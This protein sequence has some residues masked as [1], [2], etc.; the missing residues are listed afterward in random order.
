MNII[1]LTAL[2]GISLLAMSNSC[3]KTTASDG[4]CPTSPINSTSIAGLN[5]STD[6]F[7]AVGESK[8][9]VITSVAQ[10]AALFSCGNLPTIDFGTS[11]LLT[12]KIQSPSGGS[13]LSQ[14]V[15]QTCNGYTYIVRVK[16]GITAV[17]IAIPYSVVVAKLPLNAQV[18]F[19]VQLIP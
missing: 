18:N 9:H 14:Q 5:C 2:F 11:T 1:R 7:S 4:P 6:T 16:Q 12:G 15:V 3:E 10:Y 8:N 19:D 17:V 13:V